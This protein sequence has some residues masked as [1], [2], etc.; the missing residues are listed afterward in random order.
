MGLI[1]LDTVLV[2]SFLRSR[3]FFV[4]PFLLVLEGI[5]YGALA[6]YS[7]NGT[8]KDPLAAAH[9]YGS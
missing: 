3:A 6:M 7:V 2:F 1:T 9:M 8:C 4:Y 5:V